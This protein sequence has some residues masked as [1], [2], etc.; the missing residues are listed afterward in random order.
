MVVIIQVAELVMATD[1]RARA[2]TVP[3]GGKCCVAGGP[4]GVSCGNSQHR[5]GISIHHFPHKVK[6]RERHLLWVPA[7]VRSTG[8]TGFRQTNL[9]CVGF[10]L[11]MPVTQ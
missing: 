2:S 7:F 1:T 4:N 9:F 8:L 10:I 3:V 6:D 5:K 11:T